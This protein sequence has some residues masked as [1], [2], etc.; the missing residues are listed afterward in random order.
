MSHSVGYNFIFFILFSAIKDE[1]WTI[2]GCYRSNEDNYLG[3]K[4]YDDYEK[5]LKKRTDVFSYFI[6]KESLNI[7]K[8][9]K[10]SSS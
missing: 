4:Y 1:E 6:H 5:N 8:G 7:P 9:Y 10:V 2:K 3:N